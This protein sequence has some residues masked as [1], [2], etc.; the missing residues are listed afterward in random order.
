MVIMAWE[1]FGYL[2]DVLGK[3]KKFMIQGKKYPIPL[4]HSP[5]NWTNYRR[6]LRKVSGYQGH[7]DEQ[8]KEP[9]YSVLPETYEL[10]RGASAFG[11]LMSAAGLAIAIYLFFFSSLFS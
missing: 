10:S 5:G 9:P 2:I 3:S 11:L 8:G 6:R 7:L 1:T 4:H